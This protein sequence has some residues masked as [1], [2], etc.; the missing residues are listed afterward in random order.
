MRNLT[1]HGRTAK[2]IVGNVS[3]TSR[4]KRYARS[5]RCEDLPGL[6]QTL[7]QSQEVEVARAV[8]ADRVLLPAL[9]RRGGQNTRIQSMSIWAGYVPPAGSRPPEP[10]TAMLNTG[11]RVYPGSLNGQS[12]MEFAGTLKNGS[13]PGW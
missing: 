2:R 7:P 3:D 5:A 8:G 1:V 13:M 11:A 6:P 9:P 10:P 12:A 4:K